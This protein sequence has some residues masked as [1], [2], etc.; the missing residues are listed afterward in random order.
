MLG[1]ENA[2]IFLPFSGKECYNNYQKI[3]REKRD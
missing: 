1:R 2:K 3:A